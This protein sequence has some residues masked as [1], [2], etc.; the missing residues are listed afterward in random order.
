[1]DKHL[2][3]F[4]YASYLKRRL[5]VGQV[6]PWRETDERKPIYTTLVPLETAMAECKE[7]SG[8]D[9]T[10]AAFI[11]HL[12]LNDVIVFNN[13]NHFAEVVEKRKA[14]EK[15]DKLAKK[16]GAK[17]RSISPERKETLRQQMALIHASKKASVC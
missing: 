11:D 17:R 8:Q 15:I 1:M 13:V 4:N 16:A 12:K 10:R 2:N 6:D 3:G 5:M 9:F 7:W 14:E